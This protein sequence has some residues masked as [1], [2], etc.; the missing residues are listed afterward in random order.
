MYF[1]SE[2]CARINCDNMI[3]ILEN[4]FIMLQQLGYESKEDYLQFILRN[5]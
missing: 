2:N 5:A 1:L 3:R 4:K